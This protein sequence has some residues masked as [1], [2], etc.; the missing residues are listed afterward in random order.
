M[1]YEAA[2]ALTMAGSCATAAL[3]VGAVVGPLIAT[4]TL[5][6]AAGT[7][8]PLWASGLLVLVALLAVFPSRGVIAADRSSE[9]LE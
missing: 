1:L 8:G 3:N 6:T 9:V 5:G 2:A 4:A 7:L